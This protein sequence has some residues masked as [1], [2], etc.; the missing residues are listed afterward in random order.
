MRVPAKL[1]LK[2][3]LPRVQ[4]VWVCLMCAAASG[5]TVNEIYH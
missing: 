2:I 4:G 1:T 5:V 3:A